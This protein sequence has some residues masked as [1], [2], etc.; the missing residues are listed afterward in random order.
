MADISEI[1]NIFGKEY[2]LP[3][4][5]SLHDTRSSILMYGTLMFAER[6]FTGCS[7]RDLA[8]K[9]G[10]Q[11]S[12][13]YYHFPSKDKLWEAV[14]E[15]ISH[16]YTLYLDHLNN[17]L[18]KATSFAEM[19]EILF[20][21]PRMMRNRFTCF[22]FGL[23]MNEQ[24]YR[25]DAWEVLRTTFY[26]D[27]FAFLQKWLDRAVER[28]YVKSFDTRTTT[29]MIIHTIM[30]AVQTEAQ[31]LFGRKTPYDPKEL[32]ARTERFLLDMIGRE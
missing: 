32:M 13:L 15:H 30:C 11:A 26:A 21:E 4:N 24:F 7:M 28:K 23:I 31:G 6:G 9:I 8:Q 25:E 3:L 22:G 19:L 1:Y 18:L 10:I 2:P 27:S 20:S 29:E 14:L 12:T 16:L 5:E 17:E